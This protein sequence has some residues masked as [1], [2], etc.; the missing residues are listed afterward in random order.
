[1]TRLGAGGEPPPAAGRRSLN[2]APHRAHRH[3]P[4]VLLKGQG[5][6]SRRVIPVNFRRAHGCKVH[7]NGVDSQPQA[8]F[9]PRVFPQDDSDSFTGLCVAP[10][11][12]E[13]H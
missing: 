13:F 4:I 9:L 5:G 8:V 7:P 2:H 12:S 11:R 10:L 1:M 3:L 6:D